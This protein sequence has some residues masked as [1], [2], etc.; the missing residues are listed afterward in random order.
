MEWW[1]EHLERVPGAF[2]GG[3]HSLHLDN[4][5]GDMHWPKSTE[6]YMQDLYIYLKRK[7]KM[8]INIGL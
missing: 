3:G 4:I 8:Y 5:V 1:Q 6:W 2:W 7:K